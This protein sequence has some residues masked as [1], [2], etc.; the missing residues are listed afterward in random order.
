MCGYLYL[1]ANII[2]EDLLV[3][4]LEQQF[5]TEWAYLRADFFTEY[6]LLFSC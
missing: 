3:D 1:Y 2:F 6:I 4:K 5:W